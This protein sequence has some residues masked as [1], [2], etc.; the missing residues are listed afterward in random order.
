MTTGA[1]AEIGGAW[2][3]WVMA[4]AGEAERIDSAG[5]GAMGVA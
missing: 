2:R 5:R 4:G 1:G 3:D